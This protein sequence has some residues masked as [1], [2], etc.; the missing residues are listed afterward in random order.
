MI[1]ERK[2][3][4]YKSRIEVDSFDAVLEDAGERDIEADLEKGENLVDKIAKYMEDEGVHQHSA[5][6]YPTTM[7]NVKRVWYAETEED[8]KTGDYYEKTFHVR[9]KEEDT[10]K[11]MEL[12]EKITGKTVERDYKGKPRIKKEYE[13]DY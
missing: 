4:W 13:Y 5:S 11:A 8:Y 12:Y 10:D 3:K 2:V 6:E 1:E 7:G 9:W